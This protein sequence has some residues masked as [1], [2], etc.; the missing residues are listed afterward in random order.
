MRIHGETVSV[1]LRR[2]GAVDEYGNDV[3]EYTEPIEVENV[4]VGKTG[5]K[6]HIGEGLP[7]AMEADKRFC[8]PRGWTEDLRGALITRM[9]ATYKV[10]GDPTPITDENIPRGIDWNIRADTVRFDG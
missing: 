10:I 6:D 4:L 7:Y 9:G 5:T 2:F 3:E 8:F 1:R